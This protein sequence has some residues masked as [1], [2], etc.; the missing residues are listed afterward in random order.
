MKPKLYIVTAAVVSFAA[1]LFA[2]SIIATDNADGSAYSP[3]PTHN[4]TP[5]NGGTGYGTWTPLSDTSGGGTYMEGTSVNNAQV[6]GNY[7]FALYAGSGSYDVSRPLSSSLAVGDFSILTRFN[8]AG[9]GPNLVNLRTGNNT[10]TFGS[11]ELISF[12][13]VGGNTLSYTD[14]SGFHTIASGEARGAVWDWNVNFNA[15]AGTYT[16]SVTNMGGGFADTIVGNLEQSSTTVGSFGVINSSSGGNQNVIF[17]A[18]TFTVPE[19]SSVFLGAA[20]VA[21]LF[22]LRRRS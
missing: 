21:T 20:G 13:I 12:G 3:Q 8:I 11:G 14:S 17:D 16:L 1:P 22:L 5:I 10:T 9:S 6:D 4:W 2:Q 15:T 7:S 18:P 19:P